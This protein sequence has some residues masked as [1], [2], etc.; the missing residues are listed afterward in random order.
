MAKFIDAP[1]ILGAKLLTIEKPARYVGGEYGI[2]SKK[3]AGFQTVIAFP[4]LYEVG[5]S[6]KALRILYNS[7]NRLDGISCERVFALPPEAETLFRENNI[8]LYGLDNGIVVQSADLLM[9]TF[10]YELGITGILSILETS[11]IPLRNEERGE[12][13]PLVIAGGPCVSNPL[14]YC[15][16]I[17]A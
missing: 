13:D 12:D 14:P 17:D 4:D 6:N 1:R 11:G 7:L 5:M 10:G 9:F 2:L 16:F 8:R 3:D 15:N